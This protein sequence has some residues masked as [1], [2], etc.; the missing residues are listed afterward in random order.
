MTRYLSI[1][2]VTR[3]KYDEP[4]YI[5]DVNIYDYQ[6]KTLFQRWNTWQA[7]IKENGK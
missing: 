6:S 7:W 3:M 2:P 4:F 1:V 5:G